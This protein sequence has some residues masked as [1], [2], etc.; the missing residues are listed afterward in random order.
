M[1][2]WTWRVTFLIVCTACLQPRSAMA[3]N[4][5][6]VVHATIS[7][8]A[9]A[10]NPDLS[11][12][13]S[14]DLVVDVDAGDTYRSGGALVRLT[15]GSFFNHPGGGD[16]PPSPAIV[17]AFPSAAYDTHVSSGIPLMGPAIIG[18]YS[19]TGAAMVGVGPDFNVAWGPV[20][21]IPGPVS[22]S[23]ARLTFPASNVGTPLEAQMITSSAPNGI[24][25]QL[26]LI[27]E[28]TAQV[29]FLAAGAAGLAVRRQAM[30]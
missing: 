4:R 28:P 5:I 17:G 24:T 13:L 19:G 27:P 7:A 22:L 29:V 16:G 18:G 3:I 26:A 1:K 25:F 6:A 2:H 9:L 11:S 8:A 23:I 20:T 21:P 14:L 12:H 30:R 10:D 15:A